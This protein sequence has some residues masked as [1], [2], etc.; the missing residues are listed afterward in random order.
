ML[1][2]RPD[3]WVEAAATLGA[4][5]AQAWWHVDVA[6]LRRPLIAGAG[7][8]AAISLGEFGATSFLTRTGQETLPITIARLLG[9]AGDL[10]RAQAFAL[11]TILAAATVAVITAV[12]TLEREPDDA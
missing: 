9:R 2:S 6:V 4:S 7:F 8:A 12:E 1:R 11:A 10:P 5:P 3:G